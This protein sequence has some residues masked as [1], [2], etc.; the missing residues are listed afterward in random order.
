M[1]KKRKERKGKKEKVKYYKCV[2]FT[3]TSVI[4]AHSGHPLQY[5][6]SQKNEYCL[7]E[8]FGMENPPGHSR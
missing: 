6:T 1:K 7:V 2:K 8:F 5:N 4:Y 3:M